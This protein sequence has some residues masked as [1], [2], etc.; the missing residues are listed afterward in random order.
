MAFWSD[1]H[2]QP[3]W[4]RAGPELA[5]R[6]RLNWRLLL[7]VSLNILAWL[8]IVQVLRVLV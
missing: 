7:A 8:A 3:A 4:S 1:V 5:Q 2:A 6:P